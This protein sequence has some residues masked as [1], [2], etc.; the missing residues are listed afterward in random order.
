MSPLLAL[1]PGPLQLPVLDAIKS[2]L[3][4]SCYQSAATH[5]LLLADKSAIQNQSVA[6]LD[7]SLDHTEQSS[8]QNLT[9]AFGV[10]NRS[11]FTLI[12]TPFSLSSLLWP[13]FC[14]LLTTV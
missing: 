3:M 2:Q 1:P 4:I 10:I 6:I 7:H 12:T 11:L 14:P 13:Q 5:Y 9:S 8:N